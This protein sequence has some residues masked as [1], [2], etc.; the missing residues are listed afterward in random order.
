[1]IGSITAR[2]SASRYAGIVIDRSTT[3]PASPPTPTAGTVFTSLID[4]APVPSPQDLETEFV[5]TPKRHTQ[6]SSSASSPK[7]PCERCLQSDA[8]AP[9][10]ETA[11]PPIRYPHP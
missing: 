5:P 11:T 8:S 3:S 7:T 10:D 1:M 6:D 4:S 9:A 2:F